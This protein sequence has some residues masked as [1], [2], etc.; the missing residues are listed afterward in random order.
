M[1]HLK[2]D[3]CEALDKFLKT[4]K[5]C[6]TLAVLSLLVMGCSDGS[7]K[8]ESDQSPSTEGA[9]EQ[10]QVSIVGDPQLADVESDLASLDAD[11]EVVDQ[12]IAELD[13][14]APSAKPPISISTHKS[15]QQRTIYEA[16][17]R[18]PHL[19]HLDDSYRAEF[20]LDACISWGFT[21]KRNRF[22]R[23][24]AVVSSSSR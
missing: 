18:T 22:N 5:R 2:T 13:S 16:S 17:L 7:S 23:R 15:S 3:R 12:A 11:L 6:M 14:V 20:E 8:S 4:T 10:T 24:T 9:I 19:G 1:W 21:R